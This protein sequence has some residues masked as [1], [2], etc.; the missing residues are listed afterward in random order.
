ME[1]LVS[2]G[3]LNGREDDEDLLVDGER[4]LLLKQ[5]LNDG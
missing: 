1:D 4:F 3:K 5:D 2:R